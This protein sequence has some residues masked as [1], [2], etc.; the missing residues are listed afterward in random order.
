MCKNCVLSFSFFG[1]T[2]LSTHRFQELVFVIVAWIEIDLF[3]Q[4]IKLGLHDLLKML[5]K[6]VDRVGGETLGGI[7]WQDFDSNCARVSEFV[8]FHGIKVQVGRG[9]S[10]H[11]RNLLQFKSQIRCLRESIFCYLLE[12]EWLNETLPSLKVVE[13]FESFLYLLGKSR[14]SSR[15]EIKISG[16]LSLRVLLCV[17]FSLTILLAK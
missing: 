13:L 3:V 16:S 8:L 15:I 2:L 17:T 4:L 14:H 9:D 1:L 11:D 10:A 7:G 12:H 5:D 6:R